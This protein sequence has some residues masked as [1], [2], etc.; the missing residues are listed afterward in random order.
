MAR[1]MVGSLIHMARGRAGLEWLRDLVENP[2]GEKSHHCAPADGLYLV[3]VKYAELLSGGETKDL[4]A[5][6]DAG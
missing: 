5:L 6:P 1:I 3:R 2:E 4:V